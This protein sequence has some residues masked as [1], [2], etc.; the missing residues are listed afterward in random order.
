[1]GRRLRIKEGETT[2]DRLFSIDR[3]ACVGCC[4]LAPV[5]VIDITV[6]GH[7]APS[8]VEGLILGFEIEEQRKKRGKQQGESK[9]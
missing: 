4:S 2:S 1:M 3:V 9:Q 6:H 5:A 8:K 7:M